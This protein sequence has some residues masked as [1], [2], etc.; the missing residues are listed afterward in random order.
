MQMNIR[1]YK[2]ARNRQASI[3]WKD[4]SMLNNLINLYSSII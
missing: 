2:H 3:L 1:K 4:F